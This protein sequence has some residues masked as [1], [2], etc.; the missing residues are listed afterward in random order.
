MIARELRG[1]TGRN[2][3]LAVE[4]YACFRPGGA[5][6]IGGGLWLI[7]IRLRLICEQRR[8]R[9]VPVPANPFS[10]YGGT[11]GELADIV[12]CIA[13]FFRCSFRRDE[14]LSCNR[15]RV[16]HSS[17]YNARP[18]YGPNE[19]GDYVWISLVVAEHCDPPER[20][21]RYGR[22]H[23]KSSTGAPGLV[24]WRESEN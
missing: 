21:V 22:G 2:K 11:S 1:G 3:I 17:E 13:S 7:C 10:R 20:T 4:R 8:E 5:R 14:L 6:N 24:V 18:I 12:L 9:D 15:N 23:P 16:G 19:K